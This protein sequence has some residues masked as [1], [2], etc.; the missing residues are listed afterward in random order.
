MNQATTVVGLELQVS[1]GHS[2]SCVD[3]GQE[4]WQGLVNNLCDFF[5]WNFEVKFFLT[6]DFF[7]YIDLKLLKLSDWFRIKNHGGQR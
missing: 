4:G 7:G 2:A 5:F 1:H 6:N 3:A